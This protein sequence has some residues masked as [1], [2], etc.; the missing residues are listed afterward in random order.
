MTKRR[1]RKPVR[2]FDDVEIKY[3]AVGLPEKM[4]YGKGKEMETA[5]RKKE[6]QEVFLSKEGF[7]GDGVADTKN[8]GGPDRAVCIYPY[9][10][11]AFWNDYFSKAL[12]PAAFGENLTVTNML[13]EQVYIGDIFR[14]GEAVVQVTQ[15]RVP[16][17][18]IDR[19]LDMT[20]L[21]KGMVKTGFSGY[22]CRVL[23]EGTIRSDSK[24]SL[25]KEHPE[26]VSV[27]FANHLYFHQ[28]KNKE[29]L[30]KVLRVEE[31]AEKWRK[32]LTERLMKLSA[33][34]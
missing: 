33:N 5:I 4:E 27:L 13:E 26:Q 12:P 31:L 15:G 8:H 1:G 25:V 29:G 22:L 28:P 18:T 34:N 14:I 17:N 7:K 16:C 11:Y 2:N 20:P 6:V 19:R 10:H 23:E 24:I 30:E 21:L 32:A 3:F 9:E